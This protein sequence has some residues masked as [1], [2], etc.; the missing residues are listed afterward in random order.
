MNLHLNDLFDY[1]KLTLCL[2]IIILYKTLLS[3][4]KCTYIHTYIQQI[5][6]MMRFLT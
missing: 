5:R 2:Y 6:F 4:E 3:T 1:N